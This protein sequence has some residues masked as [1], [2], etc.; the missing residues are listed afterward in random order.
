MADKFIPLSEVQ[1][2][3]K[4]DAKALWQL[5]NTSKI[6]WKWEGH[7]QVFDPE[8]IA[9][10]LGADGARGDVSDNERIKMV[11]E[12]GVAELADK[13]GEYSAEWVDYGTLWARHGVK[14]VWLDKQ[15]RE[16]KIR[17]KL[18]E[19]YGQVYFWPDLEKYLADTVAEKLKGA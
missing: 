13:V 7:V 5:V 18:V 12:L 9:L 4:L 15:V 6:A 1:A 17:F 8:G 3:F 10:C 11:R 16:F 2:L 19:G 14:R